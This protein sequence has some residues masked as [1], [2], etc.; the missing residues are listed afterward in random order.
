[1]SSF[2]GKYLVSVLFSIDVYLNVYKSTS[3]TAANLIGRW[4]A[5]G[6]WIRK[7]QLQLGDTGNYGSYKKAD[8]SSVTANY[9][10]EINDDGSAFFKYATMIQGC[11]VGCATIDAQG[12]LGNFG[13]TASMAG[14][15][16]G[17]GTFGIS[18]PSHYDSRNSWGGIAFGYEAYDRTHWGN[19]SCILWDANETNGGYAQGGFFVVR[20][21]PGDAENYTKQ[22]YNGFMIVRNGSTKANFDETAYNCL[23]DAYEEA[24]GHSYP[25]WP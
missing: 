20:G 9:P 21:A 19:T 6:I 15:R 10:A 24:T 7:G 18:V 23:K 11:K 25:G 4:S 3:K 1:M 8:G 13:T 17:D 5:E 2:I 14:M 22:I 12:V 16:I